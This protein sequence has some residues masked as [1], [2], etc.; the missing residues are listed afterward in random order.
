MFGFDAQHTHFNPFEHVL[1]PTTV[2]GL[3]KKWA[4]RGDESS[5]DCS[6]VVADGVVYYGS[7]TSFL[8]ALHLPGT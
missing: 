8:Y 7:S 3:K 1:N 6:P 2:G 4:F 5:I